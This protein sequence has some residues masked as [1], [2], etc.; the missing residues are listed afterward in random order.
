MQKWTP[1][2]QTHVKDQLQYIL[3]FTDVFLLLQ[4]TMQKQ[5][6]VE[7]NGAKDKILSQVSYRCPSFMLMLISPCLI[8]YK[9]LKNRCDLPGSQVHTFLF[10]RKRGLMEGTKQEKDQSLFSIQQ[11]VS[12]C[13]YV[14]VY[15]RDN[16]KTSSKN[17][18]RTYLAGMYISFYAL[19]LNWTINSGECDQIFYLFHLLILKRYQNNCHNTP[20]WSKIPVLHSYHTLIMTKQPETYFN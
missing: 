5:T 10:L 1:E 6:T 16:V 11:A 12:S 8:C 18:L 9:P 20:V 13:P 17:F 2:A 7:N 4:M 19:M 14:S 3:S 15:S